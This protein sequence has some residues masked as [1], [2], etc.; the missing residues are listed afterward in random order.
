MILTLEKESTAKLREVCERVRKLVAA[1]T[2]VYEM[3]RIGVTIS[4]G[5]TE[6]D[7]KNEEFSVVVERADNC[8]YY[9]KGHGKNQVISKDDM[10]A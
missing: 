3:H 5:F 6:A 1:N 8:L 2:T 4:A 9:A 7:A 10:E